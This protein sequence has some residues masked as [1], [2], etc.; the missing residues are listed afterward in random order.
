MPFSYSLRSC[1]VTAHLPVCGAPCKLSGRRGCLRHCVGVS[2]LDRALV[3][4]VLTNPQVIGHDEDDH[5][6]SARVHMCGEVQIYF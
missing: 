5:M 3:Y 6:C 1:I 2:C 4:Y